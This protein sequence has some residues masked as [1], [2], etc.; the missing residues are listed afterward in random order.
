MM[1]LTSSVALAC[2]KHTVDSGAGPFQNNDDLI[3]ATVAHYRILHT[4][5]RG[6]TG[7]VY[8][9][10]DLRLDRPVALKCMSSRLAKNPAAVLRF[11]REARTTCALNDPHV[12]TIYDID[13][14]EGFPFIAMELLEGRTLQELL[15]NGALRFAK[16]IHIALQI[17]QALRVAHAKQV[18]H[19]DIKPANVFITQQGKIKLLDFGLATSVAITH[20]D[21]HS[22]VGTAAYM[23]PEQAQGLEVDA[24]TDLFSLGII[25]YEMATGRAPYTGRSVRDVLEHIVNCTPE[26]PRRINPEVPFRLEKVIC[27]ALQKDVE[28]RYQTASELLADLIPLK[29]SFE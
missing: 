7:T 3:G 14:H 26:L 8:A 27:K 28:R 13:A 19:R 5:G 18:V 2:L 22:I 12:C 4:L 9:A 10:R 16:V 11:Q 25:L 15:K 21:G 23:S 6:S 20:A 24:R 17:A 1:D 29:C